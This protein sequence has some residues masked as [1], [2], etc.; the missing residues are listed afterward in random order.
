MHIG[1]TSTWL[2]DLIFL[3]SF[4]LLGLP[5]L[6]TCICVLKARFETKRS[7]TNIVVFQGWS[8]RALL[9][10]FLFGGTEEGRGHH[11]VIVRLA[12]RINFV[13]LSMMAPSKVH[14]VS[15]K[16]YITTLKL[17][18]ILQFTPH[19]RFSRWDCFASSISRHL[20]VRF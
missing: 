20:M 10:F 1:P 17:P 15:G 4:F 8:H 16:L 18:F 12:I 7:S 14:L 2:I 19:L 9:L 6:V 13:I 11:I 3:N 5:L